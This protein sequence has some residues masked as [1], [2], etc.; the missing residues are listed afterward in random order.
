MKRTIAN[1]H[2]MKK[3]RV[4]AGREG[5]HSERENKWE[6]KKQLDVEDDKT[7]EKNGTYCIG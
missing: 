7:Y 5:I 1:P 2:C 3:M 6:L 4:A